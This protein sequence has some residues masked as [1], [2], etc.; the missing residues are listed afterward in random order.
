MGIILSLSL[1]ATVVFAAW[2]PSDAGPVN[3]PTGTTPQENYYHPIVT[4]PSGLQEKVGRLGVGTAPSNDYDFHVEG[5]ASFLGGVWA[6]AG[7]FLSHV[8]IGTPSLGGSFCPTSNNSSTLNIFGTFKSQGSAPNIQ[9]DKLKHTTTLA[10]GSAGLERVCSTDQGVLRLCSYE[11]CDDHP[12]SPQCIGP[13]GPID[14]GTLPELEFQGGG[15]TPVGGGTV[16][17]PGGVTPGTTT[18][19]STGTTTGGSTGG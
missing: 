18:G 14:P 6:S 3:E 10:D 15:Q 11:Y 19:S 7:S 1:V 9:N 12:T 2:A 8:C 16:I 13:V 4:T 5:N 17:N